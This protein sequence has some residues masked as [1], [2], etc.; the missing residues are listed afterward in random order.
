MELENMTAVTEVILVGFIYDR[1]VE[2]PLFFLVFL[3]VYVTTWIGNLIIIMTVIYDSQL[4]KPMYFLLANLAF[5]DVTE[6]SVTAPRMLWDLLSQKNTI[7]FN[8]CV[9]QIFFLHFIGATVVLFLMVMAADRYVDIHKPLSYMTIMNPRMLKGLLAGAWLGGFLHSIAQIALI[10]QL[11]FCGPNVLDN[12]YCDVPQVVKLACT[13]THV[14]ELLIVSNNGLVITGTF[15]ILLI[16]YTFILVKIRSHITKGKHKALST[17]GA[18]ITVVILHFV[19]CIFIYARPFKK[20]TVDKSVSLLYT[21]ISPVVNPMIYTLRNTEMKTAIRRSVGR[22][23]FSR[24][25]QQL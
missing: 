15:N 10:V 8:G 18:Q 16:S 23:L 20:F 21:I 7:S 1:E 19:P 25:V 11:P 6:S 13:D 12:F 5:L 24:S 14:V 4:H 22:A 9:T 2:I 17:C 3:L